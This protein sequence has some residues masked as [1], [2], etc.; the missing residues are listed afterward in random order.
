MD[1]KPKNFKEL[2]DFLAKAEKPHNVKAASIIQAKST[3]PYTT[4]NISRDSFD[5]TKNYDRVIT[6][7]GVPLVDSDLNE[8]GEIN[9]NR[10]SQYMG[11]FHST[12][13]I[14][15]GGVTTGFQCTGSGLSESFNI[16]PGLFIYANPAIPA[17]V[18]LRCTGYTYSAQPTITVGGAA[19]TPPAT[20]TTPSS[21]RT[22]TIWLEV[23][24]QDYGPLDDANLYLNNPLISQLTDVS[25]RMKWI[26]VVRVWEGSGALSSSLNVSSAPFYNSA[27]YYTPL[28]QLARIASQAVINSGNITDVRSVSLSGHSTIA[29]TTNSILVS[30]P[31]ITATSN[32]QLT[33]DASYNSV[34]PTAMVYVSSRSVVNASGGFTVA[35]LGGGNAPTGGTTF[36]YKVVI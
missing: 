9:S 2:Q 22:D 23:Y 32:I 6:E 26:A 19:V 28:A 31:L 12:G 14:A 18:V 29:A 34:T 7:L 35:L 25:H 3:G 17:G 11:T 36:S 27:R 10:W 4:A 15:Y 20:L 16:G 24:Q 1:G 8:A 33:L 13:P 30:L 5:A 21:S